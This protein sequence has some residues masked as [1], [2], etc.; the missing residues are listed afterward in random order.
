MVFSR[1]HRLRQPLHVARLTSYRFFTWS[2]SRQL[3]PHSLIIS[4]YWD[5]KLN[6]LKSTGSGRVLVWRIRIDEFTPRY[7]G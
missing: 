6:L 1:G 7:L 4:K 5:L 2:P 3:E